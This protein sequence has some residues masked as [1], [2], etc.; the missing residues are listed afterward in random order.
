MEDT[1]LIGRVIKS[2]GATIPILPQYVKPPDAITSALRELLFK[3]G[4]TVSPDRPTWD[5]NEATIRPE[6][7]K[8]PSAEPSM[9]LT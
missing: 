9:T 8:D 6:W 7:G 2:D 5:L 3:S 1:L 4:Y